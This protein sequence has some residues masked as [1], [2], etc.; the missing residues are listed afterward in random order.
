VI[1]TLS[2]CWADYACAAW[3]RALPPPDDICPGATTPPPVAEGPTPVAPPYVM[4]D[5][6]LELAVVVVSLG[7]A[8]D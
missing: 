4:L 5:L 2:Y 3:L 7:F 1:S 6:T 8:A